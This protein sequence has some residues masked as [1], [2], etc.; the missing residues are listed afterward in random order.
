M[1]LQVGLV[2]L[3]FRGSRFQSHKSHDISYKAQ[4]YAPLNSNHHVGHKTI[5]AAYILMYGLCS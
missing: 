4:S 1:A 2:N 3:G 5:S